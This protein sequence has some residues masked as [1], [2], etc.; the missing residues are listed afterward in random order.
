MLIKPLSQTAAVK[1][2]VFKLSLSWGPSETC[3]F[4]LAGWSTECVI[5]TQ[6]SAPTLYSLF[7]PL[8]LHFFLLK[9]YGKNL[10]VIGQLL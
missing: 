1:S 5:P 8:I 10:N 3:C 6:V 9:P 7:F 4:A 2:F